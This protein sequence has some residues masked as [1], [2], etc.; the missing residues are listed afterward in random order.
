MHYVMHVH[1]RPYIIVRRADSE[2]AHSQWD[3]P[4]QIK[5]CIIG[6]AQT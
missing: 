2:F 1:V 4:L 3:T 5:Q 6:W